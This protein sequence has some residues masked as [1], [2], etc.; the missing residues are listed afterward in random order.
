MRIHKSYLTVL[1]LPALA[2]AGCS[3]SSDADKK[4][5]AMMS[6]SATSSAMSTS[7][8]APETSAAMD[9]DAKDGMKKDSMEKDSMEKDSMEK[10]AME[11]D[12]M[13]K[14]G[15]FVTYEQYMEHSDAAMH[16]DGRTVLFFDASWCPD[17]QKL[18]NALSSEH[19]VIPADVTVVDVDYDSHND[20]RKQYGVTMQH[21]FVE[22]DAQGN[23]VSS[24][25]IT[26]PSALN[27]KLAG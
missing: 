14:G 1:L 6:T 2:L 19:D 7:S 26:D 16:H 13:N 20:L 21:T 5:D 17:C 12:S 8:M 15:E 24:W 18:K 3:S 10:D 25:S 23:K 27:E 4:D 22:V 11:K 9:K